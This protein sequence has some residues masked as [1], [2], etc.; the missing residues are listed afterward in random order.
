MESDKKIPASMI[1]KAGLLQGDHGVKVDTSPWRQRFN[2][3]YKSL[4]EQ[5]TLLDYPPETR[6][7]VDAL[8]KEFEVSRTPIRTVLQRLE[9][10]G[11][12]ITRHGVGT[13]VTAID[14]NLVRDPLLMRMHLAELIG[15]LSP[16]VPDETVLIFLEKLLLEFDT[17]KTSSNSRKFAQ[18]D[19]Q[20]HDCKCDLIGNELLRRAYDEMYCRSA[21]TWFYLLPRMDWVTEHASLAQD[22]SMTISALK[23]GDVAAVGYITRNALSSA[24][25]RFRD[26]ISEAQE[27]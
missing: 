1:G 17:L 14:F 22:I 26:L 8:A 19:M 9:N 25:F 10:E 13:T 20:L 2:T 4:R 3:I 15:T 5:I 16:R 18:I 11:L 24:L 7:D 6:L 27:K 23:R 12:A 21:R